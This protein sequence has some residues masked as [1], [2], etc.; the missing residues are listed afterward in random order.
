MSGSLLL[1]PLVIPHTR[2]ALVGGGEGLL[3]PR[4]FRSCAVVAGCA[5][6]AAVLLFG[7]PARQARAE[8]DPPSLN[9][10]PITMAAAFIGVS[11]AT[12]AADIVNETMRTG[13]I[14][15]HVAIDQL[16]AAM[17]MKLS[18]PEP[19]TDQS[20]IWTHYS[21]I[22][23]HDT[24]RDAL[25]SHAVTVPQGRLS[26]TE[27][28]VAADL[29]RQQPRQRRPTHPTRAGRSDRSQLAIAGTASF[30]RANAPSARSASRLTCER[31]TRLTSCPSASAQ[32]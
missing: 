9:R 1:H 12:L 10:D 31:R 28:W 15:V 22:V 5:V 14:G 20:V 2:G 24:I 11:T 32:R 26:R 8:S 6:L 21:V 16:D 17:S 4:M 23:S 27:P 29:L 13:T 19:T 18:A 3:K 7:A 30:R 25:L